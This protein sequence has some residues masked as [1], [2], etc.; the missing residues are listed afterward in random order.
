MKAETKEWELKE[1]QQD[2]GWQQIRGSG[3]GSRG[4]GDSCVADIATV[5]CLIDK[6]DFLPGTTRQH[7]PHMV[8]EKPKKRN[9]L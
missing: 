2:G 6:P 1:K 4:A 9:I 3:G 5:I 7:G 8:V